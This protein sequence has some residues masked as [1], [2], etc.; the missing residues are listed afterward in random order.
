MVHLLKCTLRSANTALKHWSAWNATVFRILIGSWRTPLYLVQIFPLC[1][2]LTTILVCRLLVPSLLPRLVRN[3]LSPIQAYSLQT[4]IKS[5]QAWRLHWS[6]L[7]G[8][9]PALRILIGRWRSPPQH[10]VPK[11]QQNLRPETKNQKVCSQNWQN[12]DKNAVHTRRKYNQSS[13]PL[14]TVLTISQKLHCLLH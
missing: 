11:T 9:A 14:G 3:V 7:K 12:T 4:C 5:V 1:C 8:T 6:V 13:V 10:L 2:R